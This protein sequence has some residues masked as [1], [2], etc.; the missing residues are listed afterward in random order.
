VNNLKNILKKCY[1]FCHFNQKNKSSGYNR[2]IFQHRLI[3]FI[4]TNAMNPF[5]KLSNGE[6]VMK[7]RYKLFILFAKNCASPWQLFSFIFIPPGSERKYFSTQT[8]LFYSYQCNEPIFKNDK[9]VKKHEKSLQTFNTFCDKSCLK[10][11]WSV[12]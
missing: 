6:K 7:S 9:W 8:D 5:S 3:D 10:Y 4:H 12:A 2:T 1:N 11:T